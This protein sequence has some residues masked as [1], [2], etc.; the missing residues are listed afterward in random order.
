MF[1]SLT[2]AIGIFIAKH[3]K[4]FPHTGDIWTLAPSFGLGF[5]SRTHMR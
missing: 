5:C 4:V 2:Q 3:L 1:V